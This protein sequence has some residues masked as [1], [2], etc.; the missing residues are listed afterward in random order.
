MKMLGEPLG[1]P[2]PQQQLTPTLRRP[3]VRCARA[4]SQRSGVEVALRIGLCQRT[5]IG[6]A[7]TV[8]AAW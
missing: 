2:W 3:S 6:G 1:P 5:S 4:A 8:E 7:K